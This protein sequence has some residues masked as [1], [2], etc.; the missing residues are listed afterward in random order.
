M[1]FAEERLPYR[2]SSVDMPLLPPNEPLMALAYPPGKSPLIPE[3]LY[4]QI[5]THMPIPCVDI[6][7]VANGSVLLV[8]RNDA[9]LRGSGGFPG[10]GSI[11]ASGCARRPCARLVRKSAWNAILGRSFTRPKRSSATGRGI[12]VH[13]INSCFL[14]YPIEALSSMQV[15][16]DDHHEAWKWVKSIPPDLHP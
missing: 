4:D 10:G 9:P 16:L 6:A 13:S 5:L 8:R 7:I 11:K 1:E 14:L 12:A 2:V 15:L 3:D